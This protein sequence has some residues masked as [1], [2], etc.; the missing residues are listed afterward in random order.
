M[1]VTY[2][3]GLEREILWLRNRNV[4]KS[5]VDSYAKGFPPTFKGN[6]CSTNTYSIIMRCNGSST[7]I[8]NFHCM[9][10]SFTLLLLV[11]NVMLCSSCYP[12]CWSLILIL[13]GA[14]IM[15]YYNICHILDNL[16]SFCM[17][18]S[19]LVSLLLWS[20][21]FMLVDAPTLRFCY[22]CSPHSSM[23]IFSDVD[24]ILYYCN[25]YYPS[26]MFGNT[27]DPYRRRLQ[28]LSPWPTKLQWK[29]ELELEHEGNFISE[30]EDQD[31]LNLSLVEKTETV[32]VQSTLEGESMRT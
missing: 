15:Y 29:L 12:P 3:N 8:H 4:L 26:S 32:Q 5:L 13:H 24:S 1:H 28:I 9:L 25:I 7:N 19:S 14:S 18:L 22:Y 17:L 2:V 21:I 30:T 23:Q 10:L 20:P 16:H 31:I 27:L 11:H 6:C